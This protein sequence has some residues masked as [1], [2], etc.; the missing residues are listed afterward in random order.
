MAGVEEEL[1]VGGGADDRRRVRRHRPQ[2]GPELGALDVAAAGE[3]VIHD[4]LQGLAPARVEGE[5]EAGEFGHATDADA[6]VEAGHRHL[7]GF[8]EHGG[9]RRRVGID[10]R[11][12]QRVALDRV[13]RQVEPEAG[14][15]LARVAA[16]GEHIA[17]G[18]QHLVGG[19]GRGAGD[20]HA[21]DVAVAAQ[22]FAHLDA[23]AEAHARGPCAL[24]EAGGEQLAVTGF[25]VRQAQAAGERA[26]AAGQ[27]G[28]GAGHLGAAQQL[29]RHAAFFQHR[30]VARGGVE[31]GLGAEQLQ[32]AAAALL[33]A[34]ADLGTQRAQAVAAVLGD[35]HHA[36]LV[37]RVARARAVGQ[38]LRHPAQLE[39]AAVGADRQRCMT[40]EQPLEGLERDAGRGPRRRV[41]G[42]DLAGV[43]KAGL[44]RGVGLTVDHRDL[45]TALGQIPGRGGADHAAA[46]YDYV[47]FR[48]P[49]ESL[50]NSGSLLIIA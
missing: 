43:G 46:E 44:E 31:L 13:H 37:H 5:I 35:A 10:Q 20:A 6:L 7:V 48:S 24:G 50:W 45:G 39:Q 32:G 38:H 8:V 22:Q 18:A 15:H 21:G 14:G 17:V 1:G 29:E 23:E 34:D 4:H 11:H 28:L 26:G 3:E 12:G 9:H 30:D 16:E 27:R 25:I 41:P 36:F 47:H 40:L 19:V 33:V 49:D 42:R 2:A